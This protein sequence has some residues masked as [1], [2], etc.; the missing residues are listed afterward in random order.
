MKWPGRNCGWHKGHRFEL[1]PD[2]GID[3]DV[4]YEERWFPSTCS[5]CGL[6]VENNLAR[7]LVRYGR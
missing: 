2:D 5:R 3:P 4:P 7:G 6:K 1:D